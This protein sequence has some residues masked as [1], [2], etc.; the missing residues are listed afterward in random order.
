M[1]AC[2]AAFVLLTASLINLRW[3]SQYVNIALRKQLAKNVNICDNLSIFDSSVQPS[4]KPMC[5]VTSLFWMFPK[6]LVFQLGSKIKLNFPVVIAQVHN[7]TSGLPVGTW[8]DWHQPWVQLVDC[9][10]SKKNTLFSKNNTSWYLSF[11]WLPPYKY[12]NDT[13][14]TVHYSIYY[15]VDRWWR[16][17][18]PVPPV[19]KSSF[20]VYDY[21]KPKLSDEKHIKLSDFPGWTMEMYGEPPGF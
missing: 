21:H 15:A 10:P 20:E 19:D 9:H 16:S 5:Y 8:S 17:S 1:N 3:S 12:P 2:T 6:A 18:E 4:T 7:E 14:L 13:N 11:A